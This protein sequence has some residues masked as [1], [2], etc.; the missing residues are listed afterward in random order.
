MAYYGTT[1]NIVLQKDIQRSE[2]L[3]APEKKWE[4]LFRKLNVQAQGRYKEKVCEV[5]KLSIR[6]VG[7][8]FPPYEVSP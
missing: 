8:G 6:L 5:P 3:Q 7:K 1:E 4:N 2:R